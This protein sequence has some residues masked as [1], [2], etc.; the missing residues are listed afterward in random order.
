VLLL[1]TLLMAGCGGTPS[2]TF[3][4]PSPTASA[5]PLPEQ[6]IWFGGT[7]ADGS[8]PRFFRK[9]FMVAQTPT[10]STLYLVGPYFSDLYLNGGLINRYQ[11]VGTILVADRPVVVLDV[12]GALKAGANTIAIQAST[13]AVLALKI[14][15]GSAGVDMPPLVLSDD[16]WR[17]ATTAPTGWEQPGFDDSG[18]SPAQSFGSVEGDFHHFQGNFDLGMYQWPG[19]EGASLALDHTQIP[20]VAVV[21]ATANGA[22]FSNT[23]LL[24]S[25]SY[26]QNFQVTLPANMMSSPSLVLDFGK[27]ISGRLEVASASDAPIQLQLNLGESLT[28]ASGQNTYWGTR[29]LVVPAHSTVHGPL[30]GYRYAQIIF[31]GGPQTQVFDHISTD[32][33]VLNVP[34]TGSF[35]SSDATLDQVWSVSAD[36][37]QLNLQSLLWDAPKR[38]RNSYSGDLFVAARSNQAAF[39]QNQIVQQSLTDML[40]RSTADL[41]NTPPYDAYW[42]LA[43]EDQ[44]R[45]S[46]D[47]TYLRSNETNLIQILDLMSS[48]LT[49]N[50]YQRIDPSVTVFA[51]WSPGMIEFGSNPPAEASKIASFLFV[52]GLNDGAWLLTELGDTAHATQYQQT[53]ASVAAA[54][55]LAYLDPSTN[56]FGQRTQT[57]AMAIF[58]GVADP[59][60][61]AAIY[62]QVL[63]LPPTQPVSPFFNYFVLEAMAQA[64][65]RPEAL[66]FIRQYWG[67]MLNLGAT[68]FWEI[69]D[70]S[71]NNGDWHA[72]MTN[73]FN[74]VANQGSNRYFVSLAH[75]WSSGPA[76]WLHEQ[77]LGITP[78]A[79]GFK[80][81]QIRPDL[82]WLQFAGGTELTPQ[83][84]VSIN[85]TSA[86]TSVQLDLPIGADA[87]ISLLSPSQNPLVTVN[88]ASQ[89]GTLVENNTRTSIYLPS[90]GTRHFDLQSF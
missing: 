81:L 12:T 74:S 49:Q 43:L 26:P 40:N 16:T 56:T 3:T 32:Q 19:Y 15:P 63:A 76:A 88:G 31:A 2:T 61:T 67:G 33:A 17:A 44:Y 11:P 60:S 89:M 42:V 66:D 53:A 71:F 10:T 39:A 62:S 8:S 68:S 37:V 85:I 86:G 83:G 82:A 24:T 36:T 1:G 25:S 9:S 69:Y 51:D 28:E 77:I 59:S 48:E 52:K 7:S 18:W 64:D 46:G 27:E 58:S 14:V 75:G 78:Y 54:T 23:S 79:P 73:F 87:Y 30:T 41:N 47:L 29:S 20:A 22:T 4:P 80:T 84:T 35:S 55:T 72:N 50:L 65:H 45:F 21:N 38:D 57:N 34:R 6:Y 70:P 90:T 13:S 5:H